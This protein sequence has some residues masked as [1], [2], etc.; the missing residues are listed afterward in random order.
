MSKD[1]GYAIDAASA[2][3]LSLPVASAALAAF[4]RAIADGLG[5]Q[6]FA[7]ITKLTQARADS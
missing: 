2:E 4:R 5:D 3:G 7:A 1:I 6:D